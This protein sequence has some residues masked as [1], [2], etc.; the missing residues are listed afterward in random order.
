VAGQPL[1]SQRL[2]PTAAL[3]LLDR[4]VDSLQQ[5][6]VARRRG[7]RIGL[8]AKLQ[9]LGLDTRHRARGDDPV[10]VGNRQQCEVSLPVGDRLHPPRWPPSGDTAAGRQF[11]TVSRIGSLSRPRHPSGE[12]VQRR[13][14][15]SDSGIDAGTGSWG[16]T[17]NPV[18][19]AVRRRR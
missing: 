4:L 8:Q 15:S 12:V 7:K 17:R 3:E 11:A 10:A 14:I 1:Q 19:G 13:R 16:G 18:A 5:R 6:G 9:R 2:E